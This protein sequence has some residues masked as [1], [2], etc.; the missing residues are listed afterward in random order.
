MRRSELMDTTARGL[1]HITLLISVW[2]AFRGHN[3]PGGG[4][5]GGLVAAS[6]FVMVYLARGADALRQA[7]RLA[8]ST[9]I[10]AGLITSVIT[11]LVPVILGEQLLESDLIP[12]TVPVIGDVKLATS[13]IFDLGVYLLVVGVVLLVISELGA[14]FGDAEGD[15]L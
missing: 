8:P 6:A 11:A 9:L 14:E 3:A 15:S 5:I 12:F 10:G 2:M 13:V 7:V 4:F 1:F